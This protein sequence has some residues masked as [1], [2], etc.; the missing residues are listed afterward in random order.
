MPDQYSE[1]KRHS[2]NFRE[3]IE[4]FIQL[5]QNTLTNHKVRQALTPVLMKRVLKINEY[6]AS[7]NMASASFLEYARLIYEYCETSRNLL[8]G[9]IGGTHGSKMSFVLSFG[10]DISK[11][12]EEIRLDLDEINSREIKD[13][14]DLLLRIERITAN[15]TYAV[16]KTSHI[17]EQC[18]NRLYSKEFDTDLSLSNSFKRLNLEKN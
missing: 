11:L 2:A 12:T 1:I 15:F 10:M 18:F 8:E 5:V 3:L 13:V 9:D 4:Q 7:L 6:L 17:S 16:K 14:T